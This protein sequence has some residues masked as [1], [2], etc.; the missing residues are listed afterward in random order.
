MGQG[1]VVEDDTAVPGR[2][3]IVNKNPATG[4]VISRV[5][6]T[7]TAELEEMI[8]K[9]NA[10]QSS[11]ATV[12]V[13]ERI[14]LLKAGIAAL[15]GAAESLPS[16]MTQEMG[17]PLS[18]SQEEIE[19]ALDK[20]AMLDLLEQSLQP[21]RHGNNILVIR[22]AV[23]VVAVLSPWNYPADE[24]LLLLLP[25]LGSGNTGEPKIDVLVPH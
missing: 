12:E 16:L 18:Q 9:A 7:T 20:D 14:R 21:K 25:A 23:G 19:G 5:P 6:C 4:Q 17:K 3:V 1:V 11:W 22:Q 8:E 24:I 15:A 2:Q 10:A 13:S